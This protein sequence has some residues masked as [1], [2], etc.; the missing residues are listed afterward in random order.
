MLKS[1]VHR[2]FNELNQESIRNGFHSD[3]AIYS[4]KGEGI[5]KYPIAEFCY[6]CL[7]SFYKKSKDGFRTFI[8]I[9]FDNGY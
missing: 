7:K 8:L 9:I 6:L 1:F 5:G 3:F 2:A 4:T